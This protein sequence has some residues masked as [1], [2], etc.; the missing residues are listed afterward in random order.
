MSQLYRK[1]MIV[2][3]F[4]LGI[5][6]CLNNRSRDL[7]EGFSTSNCPNL[8]IKKDGRYYLRNTKKA[9]VPGVNPISFENLAEYIEFTK[10]QRGQGIRCPVLF[11]QET[12][13][14]Q[15]QTSYRIH[16]DVVDTNAGLPPAV[17]NDSLLY[18]AGRDKPVYNKNNMPA[19]DP[20]GQY[21]GL[22]TPLDK[23]FKETAGG[24]SANAMNTNWGGEEFSRNVVD[25]GAYIQRTRAETVDK[26]QPNKVRGELY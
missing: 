26:L 17:E 5:Y 10:W 16:P 23:M 18:D 15:G 19:Y 9:M 25:R 2:L 1:G 12:E 11:A 6:F 4:C 21:I 20:M 7:I 22:D 3:I 8:L 14:A 13:D 24:P